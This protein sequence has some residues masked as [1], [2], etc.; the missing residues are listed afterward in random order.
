VL[1]CD[2]AGEAAKSRAIPA[3]DVFR[4]A[5]M[6]DL[7]PWGDPKPSPQHWRG[8]IVTNT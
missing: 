8:E 5:T 7:F 3:N 6:W 4:I 1:G 2:Q